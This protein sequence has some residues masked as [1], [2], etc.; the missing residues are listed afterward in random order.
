MRGNERMLRGWRSIAKTLGLLV[1]EAQELAKRR[2]DP[3][4][5]KR[6]KATGRFTAWPPELRDWQDREKAREKRATGGR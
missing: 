1:Y 4:P 2:D 5:V 3:L 6:D